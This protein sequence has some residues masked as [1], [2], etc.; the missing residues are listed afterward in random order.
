MLEFPRVLFAF[1]ATG[2]DNLKRPIIIRDTLDC[3]RQR[4]GDVLPVREDL[5]S[6]HT[7]IVHEV[8][9]DGAHHAA[10]DS[11]KDQARFGNLF[12]IEPQGPF[13]AVGVIMFQKAPRRGTL[14]LLENTL[15]VWAV[16]CAGNGGGNLAQ[17]IRSGHVCLLS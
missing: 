16:L 10:I 1:D 6:F 2:H 3:F 11:T 14:K 7:Q 9:E 12:E 5:T 17:G 4:E 15:F 13:R 8:G